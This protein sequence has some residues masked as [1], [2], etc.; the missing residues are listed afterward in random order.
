MHSPP[1]VL[2]TPLRI[3]QPGLSYSWQA[4]G[5][6]LAL[7]DVVAQQKSRPPKAFGLIRPPGHHA[8]SQAPMGFCLLNNVAI[9]TRYAQQR[10]GL[11]KV[12]LHNLLA[13]LL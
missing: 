4:V 1:H 7:V 3:Q 5:A 6:A 12:T 11:D 8:L 13:P 2:A 10:H 9:A